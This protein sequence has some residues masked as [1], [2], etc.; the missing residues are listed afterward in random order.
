MASRCLSPDGILEELF[1]N[2]DDD[3]DVEGPG[4][5]VDEVDDV[6][7]EPEVEDDD[8]SSGE[9]DEGPGPPSLVAPP[10]AP[11]P[12]LTTS[13]PVTVGL[14]HSMATSVKPPRNRRRLDM[15]FLSDE[16]DGDATARRSPPAQLGPLNDR[17]S[18]ASFSSSTSSH[19]TSGTS[20]LATS[21]DESELLSSAELRS[22]K[23]RRG[24][25]RPAV[26]DP[27]RILEG[28]VVQSKDK[29]IWHTTPHPELSRIDSVRTEAGFPSSVTDGATTEEEF[30]SLFFDDTMLATM[31]CHTTDKMTELAAKYK[32]KDQSYLK[33]LELM[34][35]KSLVGI[36]IMAGL[37]KDN[38]QP[39]HFMWNALEGAPLYRCTMP[40]RR[41]TF[42]HRCLHFD[43]RRTIDERLKTD[44][45]A[46]IRK[47]WDM[48]MLHCEENYVPGPHLTVDEQLLGYRG[49]C[50][51]R[52]Y[53][54]NKPAK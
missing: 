43:D 40:E 49:N 24:T 30:L 46:H 54:P 29:T 52:M 31:C 14:P 2:I 35:M 16:D 4:D 44:K 38:R 10:P 23:R 21:E 9:W 33:P 32:D 3:S 41:F 51:F 28:N 36:L 8:L 1:K 17:A 34:E 26:G 13:T 20:A 12:T 15:E 53:I 7:S 37:K 19:N 6:V 48:L 22:R 25:L 42:L 50:S 5:Y 11:P 47:L 39:S 45:L 27:V 18:D